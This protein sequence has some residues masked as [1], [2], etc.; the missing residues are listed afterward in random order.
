[1]NRNSARLHDLLREN[2][3]VIALKDARHEISLI[4]GALRRNELVAVLPGIYVLPDQA[5]APR[6]RVAALNRH[7]P[8]TIFTGRTAAGLT[9]RPDLLTSQVFAAGQL[10]TPYPGYRVTRQFIDP[11]WVVRQGTLA[12][13]APELTALDLVPELGADLIDD[14]LRLA[15]DGGDDQLRRLWAAFSA[16]PR[17]KGH[18][19]CRELLHDSRD[20]PWSAAERLA[21]RLLRQAGITG[22]ATNF[23]L[24]LGQDRYFLDLAFPRLQLCIEIDGF[25]T[26]GTRQAFE[27]DR[28]RQNALTAAGWTVLRFTWVMLTDAPHAFIETVQISLD[29]LALLR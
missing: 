12:C 6:T 22:W 11:D 18:K 26:H 14:L 4:K 25:Q 7:D 3:G 27:S 24:N 5:E 13:T 2:D 16:H 10:R 19:L 8:N 1:M 21:H 17:R 29:R 28:S 15:G 20:R 23:E 9:W